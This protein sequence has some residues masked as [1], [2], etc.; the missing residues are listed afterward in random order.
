[1]V[2]M[3]STELA[4][5]A[6]AWETA[7]QALPHPAHREAVWLVV[8]G[9]WGNGEP[10]AGV[11]WFW[12]CWRTR[13]LSRRRE[14]VWRLVRWDGRPVGKGFAGLEVGFGVFCV[15]PCRLSQEEPGGCFNEGILCSHRIG[16][17]VYTGWPWFW[18]GCFRGG[19][20]CCAR[21]C[22]DLMPP[23]NWRRIFN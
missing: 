8:H 1:M 15:G 9:V 17:E 7:A 4:C 5:G 14:G 19:N 23:R 20:Q 18:V 16:K 13:A 12:R 22:K 21:R 2:P 6:S 10:C 11:R 3:P